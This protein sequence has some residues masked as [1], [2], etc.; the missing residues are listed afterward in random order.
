MAVDLARRNAGRWSTLLNEGVT[1]AAARA[2]AS[3][4][5]ALQR[6]LEELGARIDSGE[7]DPQ[8]VQTGALQRVQLAVAEVLQGLVQ[9]TADLYRDLRAL[10]EDGHTESGAPEPAQP[11]DVTLAW[12]AAAVPKEPRPSLKEA[13][14]SLYSGLKGA[15]GGIIMV[16][17]FSGI[18]GLGLG[19]L[20]IAGVGALFG[21]K[22]ILDERQRRLQAER[23]QVK[24]ALR[25]FLDEAQTE[26][27]RAIRE[28]VRD[29]LRRE[30]EAIAEIATAFLAAKVDR[31]R[32]L[33]LE[34]ERTVTQRGARLEEVVRLQSRLAGPLQV[35]AENAPR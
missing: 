12:P 25:Q 5:K 2:E 16:G 8:A 29:E 33:T 18:A 10:F 34:R 35:L 23:Q 21:G 28:L 15:Q 24:N 32:Y 1:D 4:R 19:T 13:A 11:K 20:A 17:V 30:R 22:Q 31:E 26:G 3:L 14:G 7:L 9:S 6:I 27:V